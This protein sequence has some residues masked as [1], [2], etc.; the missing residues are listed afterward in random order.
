MLFLRKTDETNWTP[1]FQLTPYFWAIFSWSP[2]CPNFKNDIL[3]PLILGRRKLFQLDLFKYQGILYWPLDTQISSFGILGKSCW[4]KLCYVCARFNLGYDHSQR[5]KSFL[6][7]GSVV[8]WS[9]LINQAKPP[10]TLQVPSPF[11]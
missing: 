7:L 3:T 8:S 4:S 1:P 10:P 11:W 2:L 6:T 9:L 5:P